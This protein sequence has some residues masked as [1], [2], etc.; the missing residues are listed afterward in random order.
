[1]AVNEKTATAL[2]FIALMGF[3]SIPAM[4]VSY[5]PLTDYANHISR[6]YVLANIKEDVFFQEAF[7]EN[8][9]VIPNVGMDIL[10]LLL[11]KFIPIATA[12]K[13]MVWIVLF[14]VATGAMAL[15]F[16]L[17][18]RF[19]AAPLFIFAF[20][21]NGVLGFGFINYLL[22]LGLGLWG[23]SAWIYLDRR[24]AY[25]PQLGVS[26]GVSL[27]LFFAH[28]YAFAIYG[29]VIVTYEL[30]RFFSL[31]DLMYRRSC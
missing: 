10:L 24:K 8:F 25:W 19:E 1:M 22:G 15:H 11:A 16:S 18:Q 7:Q 13:L 12:S 5:P 9:Q 3:A 30:Y 31:H 26:I 29:F 27:T 6:I 2:L 21:F 20:L 28:F 23:L 14:V 4:L 17:F